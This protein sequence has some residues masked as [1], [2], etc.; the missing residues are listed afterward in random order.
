M[1]NIPASPILERFL[2]TSFVLPS[3]ARFAHSPRTGTA[4]EDQGQICPGTTHLQTSFL[5]CKVREEEKVTNFVLAF[6]ILC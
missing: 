3:G 2:K 5:S 6:L 4:P 1:T